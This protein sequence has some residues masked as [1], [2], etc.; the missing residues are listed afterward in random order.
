MKNKLVTHPLLLPSLRSSLVPPSSPPVLCWSKILEKQQAFPVCSGITVCD[1]FLT[2]Q[3]ALW[4]G[5][6]IVS[7]G[8]K[9]FCHGRVE[10]DKTVPQPL[11]LA[12]LCGLVSPPG[13]GYRVAHEWKVHM[14]DMAT[15]ALK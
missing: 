15:L 8:W 1:F 5:G 6:V 14:Q 11:C 12:E 13:G 7:S 3:A 2:S 9:P 10:K 4:H